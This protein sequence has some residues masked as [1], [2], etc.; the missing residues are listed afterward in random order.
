MRAG[1]KGKS[2]G[3]ATADSG[4]RRQRM[5]RHKLDTGSRG[6]IHSS[7]RADAPAQHWPQRGH[8]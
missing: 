3:R 6:G 5:D 2:T 7:A 8:S 4:R 1:G